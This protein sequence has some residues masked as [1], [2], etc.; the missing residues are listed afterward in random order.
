MSAVSREWVRALGQ[1][2]LGVRA[3]GRLPG[4]IGSARLNLQTRVTHRQVESGLH[5]R[6]EWGGGGVGGGRVHARQ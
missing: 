5:A 3:E 1:R 6:E 4:R 2:Y